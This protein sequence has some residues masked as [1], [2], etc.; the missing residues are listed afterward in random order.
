MVED[1][2]GEDRGTIMDYHGRIARAQEVMRAQ[3]T[4]WLLV[5]ASADLAYLV[6]LHVQPGDRL[7]ALLLPATGEATLLVPSLEATGLD[8]A[9]LPAKIRLWPDGTNPVDLAVQQL[10]GAASLGVNESLWARDL[11]PLMEQLPETRV[12]T[13][14]PTISPLRLVKD[15][16]E[17]DVLRRAA[18]AADRAF[19]RL[20]GQKLEGMTE[21][22]VAEILSD[23]LVDE[24][25][26]T[27]A[28]AIVASGPNGASPHHTPG[29]RRIAR[30]DVIVLDFGGTID[31]YYSDITRTIAVGEPEP[32]AKAVYES[33]RLAQEAGVLAVRPGT[34]TGAVDAATRGVLEAAG[35]GSNFIH[36][37]GHGLGLDVHEP[38]YIVGGDQTELIPGMV[39][40]V[41]PGAYFT[42]RFGVRIEDIV[43]VTSDSSER[44][45][46]ADRSL[47]IVE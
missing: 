13:A 17:I 38:P 1:S 28:F 21:V 24:G 31:G 15:E 25:H 44:L 5:G 16:G 37:T 42:G 30:R 36:R 32:D 8:S 6:G 39:F 40:S 47:R 2:L 19:E 43:V 4:E 26:D 29:K 46:R 45:N 20:V 9:N 41:E 12:E 11:L 27:P 3:G 33:V 10:R 14:T 23:L 34:T 18:H 22:E 7:T 35:Y